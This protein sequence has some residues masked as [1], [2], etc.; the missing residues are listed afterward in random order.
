LAVAG[1]IFLCQTP[2]FWTIFTQLGAM[3]P[4]QQIRPFDRHADGLLVGEGAGA[5][6]LKRVEDACRDGDQVYAIIK[7]VGSDTRRY[8]CGLGAYLQC[9]ALGGHLSQRSC[10]RDVA[11]PLPDIGNKL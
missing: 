7:G 10:A 11:G 9:S 1:G 3:S 5:V 4:S 8:P 2:T 6:I